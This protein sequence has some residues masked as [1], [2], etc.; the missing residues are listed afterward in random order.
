MGQNAK[1]RRQRASELAS[2]THEGGK[3]AGPASPERSHHLRMILLA[4]IP[5]VSIGGAV[6]LVQLLDSRP[7]AGML[8]ILGCA[9]WIIVFASD[10]GRNIPRRD[11]TRASGLGFGRSS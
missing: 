11:R 5:V 2:T 8:L 10:I 3:D 7:A 9:V 1:R 4:T 6:A